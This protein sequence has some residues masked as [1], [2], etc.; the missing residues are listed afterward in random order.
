MATRIRWHG[1]KF[2]N[3]INNHIEEV[4]DWGR[5]KIE[6]EVKRLIGKRG[7]GRSTQ[8]G[9]HSRPGQPPFRQKGGLI[10]SIASERKGLVAKIGSTLKPEG[11]QKH[12]YA[13]YLELGT[14]KMAKRPYLRPA[15]HKWVSKIR[16]KLKMRG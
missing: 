1:R 15:L 9:I 10:D 4:L 14:N 12:S 7:T 5:F 11:G 2:Q 6:A 3:K 13:F 16:Q 8:K